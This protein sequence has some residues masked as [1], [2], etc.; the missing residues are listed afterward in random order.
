[1]MIKPF[2]KS[3]VLGIQVN[4]IFVLALERLNSGYSLTC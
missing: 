2:L 4:H 1:M 3:I